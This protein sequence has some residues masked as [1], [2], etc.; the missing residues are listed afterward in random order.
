ML[1][2]THLH[3]GSGEGYSRWL[4]SVSR[5]TYVFS[6]LTFH[7]MTR[8]NVGN[9][10]WHSCGI[11]LRMRLGVLCTK[12]QRSKVKVVRLENRSAQVTFFSACLDSTI[13]WLSIFSFVVNCVH[14]NRLSIFRFTFR[15]EPSDLFTYL[16]LRVVGFRLEYSFEYSALHSSN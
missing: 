1:H 14:D 5:Y 11:L 9:Q 12:G 4:P 6:Y 15:C 16:K 8:I 7:R 10:I 2:V 13:V 3:Q